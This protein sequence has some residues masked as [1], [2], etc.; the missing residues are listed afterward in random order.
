MNKPE[1]ITQNDWGLL[2]E[3]YKDKINVALEKIKHNYPIQYLI[4]YVDFCGLKINCDERA[5]IPRF[6][7]EF[8]VDKTIKLIKK[9]N[10]PYPNICE[11]GTGTGCIS[12]TLTKNL[13]AKITSI[14]KSIDALNLAKEN[15][16]NH[17][18]FINL[19][20]EDIFD[21]EFVDTYD[22]I[23]SNPPYVLTNE[24]VSEE[25]KY[26][27]KMAIFSST[28]IEFYEE[29]IK[30]SVNHLSSNGIIVF[31]I[32]ANLGE[33]IKEIANLY[34]PDKEVIVEKD[35]N[36]YDRYLFIVNK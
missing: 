17:N 27:P 34:Y 5:L 28:G 11:I 31:E 7:T 3:I 16:K 18:V 6:E 29:I 13:N 35:L 2:K 14:D 26:E 10:L 8:L 12:I 19:V 30:K 36:G 25:I 1:N 22:L 21:Y 24:Y 23:I 33:N 20:N 32:G 4:G 9:N 15:A